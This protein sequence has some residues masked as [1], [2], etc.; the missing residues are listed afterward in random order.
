V[1]AAGN[2]N[3]DMHARC[4][5]VPNGKMQEDSGLVMCQTFVAKKRSGD[6]AAGGGAAVLGEG[7]RMAGGLAMGG[8]AAGAAVLAG[9]GF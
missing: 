9:M 6:A 4:P 1:S 7:G 3:I 2:F 5:V 8:L